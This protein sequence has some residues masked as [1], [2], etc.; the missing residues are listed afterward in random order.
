M[1][2]AILVALV[3]PNG[4]PTERLSIPR[5][6][7]GDPGAISADQEEVSSHDTKS[8]YKMYLVPHKQGSEIKHE[9]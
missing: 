7:H 1:H 9:R 5:A 4:A 3:R 8:K 2:R 6:G